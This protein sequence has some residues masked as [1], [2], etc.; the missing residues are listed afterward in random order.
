MLYYVSRHT[1]NFAGRAAAGPSSLKTDRMEQFVT[2]LVYIV[3]GSL[4]IAERL[5][6]VL[7]DCHY[8]ALIFS[9]AAGVP[10][11]AEKKN[12]SIF[13]INVQLGSGS[14]LALCLSLRQNTTLARIPIVLM[15]GQ[16]SE[17]ERVLGLELGADDFISTQFGPR[18]L[19]ARINAV[20]RRAVYSQSLRHVRSGPVEVDTERFVLSVDGRRVSATATQVRLVEYLMRNEGRVFNRD[21]ILDAVWRDTRFVTPRTID[22]HIRRIREMI[23]PDP[24]KPRFLKTVRGAGY[25]FASQ[26][27]SVERQAADYETD[28]DSATKIPAAM[29]V[30]ERLSRSPMRAGL[31]SV[32]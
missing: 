22:V 12:P 23:E 9:S 6:R 18:E 20:L 11:S 15:S 29:A 10:A 32:S 30:V 17:D 26:G 7:A 1:G 21:Q 13:L 2:P 3:E 4:E 28:A 24:A 14:G 31:R 27:T 25:Y 5:R 16:D 19:I 8:G